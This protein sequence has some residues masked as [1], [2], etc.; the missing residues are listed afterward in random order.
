[1]SYLRVSKQ[2]QVEGYSLQAQRAAI[3][4]HCEEHD[5][6]LIDEYADEGISARYDQINKRP[7][8]AAAVRAV[9]QGEADALAVHKLDRF[10]RN[11]RVFQ[12]AMGRMH[13]Q[14]IFVGEGIDPS[15]PHGEL[16]AGVMAQFAQFFSRNLS[17]EAKKGLDE[18]RKEGLYNGGPLPF[19]VCKDPSAPNPKRALP[20]PDTS[21]VLCTM[22]DHR[23][24]SSYDALLLI[25]RRTIE[26]VSAVRLANELRV[27]GFDLT[28]PGIRHILRNRFYLGEIPIAHEPHSPYASQYGKG[29]HDPILDPSLWQTAYDTAMNMPCLRRVN[30]VRRAAQRWSLTGLLRCER[31]GGAMHVKAHKDGTRVECYERYR[32]QRCDQPSFKLSMVESQVIEVLRGYALPH[33]VIVRLRET[34]NSRPQDGLRRIH[35]LQLQRQR[36]NEL[37]IEGSMTKNQYG[38]RAARLES[39]IAELD[40]VSSHEDEVVEFSAYLRDLP[41]MYEAANQEQR[42]R[43][44][45]ILF[46]GLM[47]NNRTLV[48]VKPKPKLHSLLKAGFE[49]TSKPGEANDTNYSKA[50]QEVAGTEPLFPHAM[51]TP[52]NTL[53]DVIP[54]LPSADSS[55][56]ES[57][58]ARNRQ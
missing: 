12:E 47:V 36:L 27:I 15:T 3:Q 53:S 7:G 55:I 24:W 16:M 45:L 23:E 56:G 33:E 35:A 28:Q 17:L 37:Y 38:E 10:A 26:G 13:N 19:G 20:I 4:R 50:T 34:D 2:E 32:R 58:L 21:P 43:M 25:F 51:S 48:A 18:R 46:N 6:E 39:E 40:A 5:Y 31:C 49:Y 41:G 1:M 11:A 54:G 8:F 57:V 22:A 52:T 44:L 9:E 14:V 42:N 30:S 29:A